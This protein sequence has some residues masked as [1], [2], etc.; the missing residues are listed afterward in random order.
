MGVFLGAIRFAVVAAAIAGTIALGPAAFAQAPEP[1]TP[2]Q[3]NSNEPSADNTATAVEPQRDEAAQTEDEERRVLRIASW[4]GAYGQAQ[5][6]AIVEPLQTELKI[7]I[8]RMT[9]RDGDVPAKTA[10]LVEIGQRALRDGCQAGTLMRIAPIDLASSVDG[11]AAAEDFIAGGLSECGVGSFAWSALMLVDLAAFKTRKPRRLGDVF[12]V[13]RFP[14]KRAFVKRPENL[15]E[16]IAMANGTPAA[17]VYD[18]LGE[19]KRLDEIFVRLG[20]LLPHVVWVESA[21][22]GL[23]KLDSG[24]VKFAMTYSGRAFRKTIA[25]NLSAIWDGHIYDHVSWAIPADA[26]NAALAKDFVVLATSPKLL[27]AQARL[28]PYGP[29]RKSAAALVGR[30][31]HLDVELAPFM[32]TSSRRL[33]TGLRKDAQFWAANRD[34]LRDRLAALLQGFPKGVRVPPPSR[35]PDPPPIETDS[36]GDLD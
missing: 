7:R 4:G 15:L 20:K 18:A 29:M 17:E 8:E 23:A 9:L 10:D 16:M 12:N 3:Q 5:T 1:E 14:G 11:A 6:R 24:E 28:W 25:G 33:T 22:A 32:P 26:R 36:E 19:R 31:A 35:R 27:A 21:Q 30:H 2:E 13:K 34:A